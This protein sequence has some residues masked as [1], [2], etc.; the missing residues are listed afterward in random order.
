[1][2]PGNP[3]GK[4][5]MP[6]V[7][8]KSKAEKCRVLVGP[9]ISQDVHVAGV[10]R[11]HDMGSGK[12]VEGNPLGVV[13]RITIVGHSE[14]PVGITPHKGDPGLGGRVDEAPV[15][16]SCHVVFLLPEFFSNLTNLKM[17]IEILQHVYL[18]Y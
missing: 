14:S 11:F 13:R 5:I 15:D 17:E 9:R 3:I 16:P 12:V 2:L 1:M 4:H 7:E 8:E 18:T 6:S 10:G